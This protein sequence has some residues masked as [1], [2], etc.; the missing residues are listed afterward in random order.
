MTDRRKLESGVLVLAV[1]SALLIVPPLV[2]IF[3]HPI[4]VFG[5]PQIVV[6]LFVVWALMVT[7]TAILTRHLPRASDQDEHVGN[8]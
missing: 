5:L 2:Y 3:N 6:Y 1:F 7:A 4:L 8:D